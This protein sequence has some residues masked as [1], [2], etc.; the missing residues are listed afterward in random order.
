M[1]RFRTCHT[2]IYLIKYNKRFVLVFSK[3]KINVTH[4]PVRSFDDFMVYFQ[5]NGIRFHGGS[6][7]LM[8]KGK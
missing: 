5:E 1:Q 2:L 4:R 6:R 7:R 3:I 8:L